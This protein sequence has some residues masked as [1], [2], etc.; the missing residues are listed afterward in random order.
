M[1]VVTIPQRPLAVAND[2]RETSLRGEIC[3]IV[4]PVEEAARKII[5]LKTL[6]L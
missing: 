4:M 6:P 2:I 5:L 3:R 1:R